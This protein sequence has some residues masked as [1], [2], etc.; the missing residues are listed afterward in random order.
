MRVL[1]LGGSGLIGN[2]MLDKGAKQFQMFSTYNSVKINYPNSIYFNFPE[3]FQYLQNYIDK[4][5]PDIILNTI[6]LSNPQFCEKNQKLAYNINVN[7]PKLLTLF[8]NRKN[9][10]LIH[11]S[12]NYVFDGK[13]G[14]YTEKDTPNPINYY[15][16]TKLLS[17]TCVLS[18]PRNLVIRT[19]APYGKSTKIRFFNYVIRSLIESKPVSIYGNYYFNPTLLDELAESILR[20][21]NLKTSGIIHICGSSCTTKF[22]F[23]K[24]ICRVFKFDQK[25]VNFNY[26]QETIIPQNVCMDNSYATNLLNYRFSTLEEGLHS[27]RTSILQQFHDFK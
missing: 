23:V 4:I 5:K 1:V 3:N 7:F 16:K 20:I 11:L 13:Q 9:I 8:T 2:L 24:T 27:I 18:N 26:E 15:G 17:E 6:A 12:T 10:R 21:F 22:D 25:L 14:Y 19:S